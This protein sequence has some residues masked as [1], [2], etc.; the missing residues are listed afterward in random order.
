MFVHLTFL[1]IWTAGKS[2]KPYQT[3]A[4]H[5]LETRLIDIKNKSH[6][7]NTQQIIFI[8]NIFGDDDCSLYSIIWKSE[9]ESLTLLYS[10]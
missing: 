7:T 8:F 6:S 1:L 4:S 10:R 5:S 9:Y 2:L 3:L